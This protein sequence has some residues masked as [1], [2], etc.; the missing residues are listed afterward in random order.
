VRIAQINNSYIFPGLAL[1][2]LVSRATRVSDSMIMAAAKAL[3]SLSP[4]RKDANAPL[5][6]PIADS[7]KV[8][9]VV[10]EAVGRQAMAEGLATA[11]DEATFAE[12]LRDYVWEPVYLPYE[13]AIS[14]A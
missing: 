2:I 9:L 1:G 3:A 7:R 14:A 10:A 4:A 8:S 12:N 5:L 11:V 6:P 13:R